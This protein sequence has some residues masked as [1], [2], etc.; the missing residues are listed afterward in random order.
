MSF[1]S[2]ACVAKKVV[3]KFAGIRVGRWRKKGGSLKNLNM[4]T[5]QDT[6]SAT[7]SNLSTKD[8]RTQCLFSAFGNNIELTCCDKYTFANRTN[9]Y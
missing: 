3:A 6:L 1:S 4:G 2:F 5:S 9:R 8:D 7:L